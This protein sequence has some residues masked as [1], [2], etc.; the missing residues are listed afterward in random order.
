MPAI[1]KVHVVRFTMTRKA[2]KK[3]SKACILRA[4]ASSSAI[5]TGIST[6]LIEKK[7]K[8]KSGKFSHLR[9]AV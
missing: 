7:L 8:S 3:V 4:V 9:L 2:L 5:E 6:L 1:L